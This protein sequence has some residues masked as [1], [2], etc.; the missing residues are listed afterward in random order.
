V[1]LS[2]AP[3]A[4]AQVLPGR[5]C[6]AVKNHWNATLRRIV[7]NGP[8]RVPITPLEK[9][10]H[11]L[12]CAKPRPGARP[13]APPPPRLAAARAP[14]LPRGA[15]RRACRRGPRAGAFVL[16][17]LRAHRCAQ[18]GRPLGGCVGACARG[19]AC[20]PA[21]LGAC[22]G[23]SGVWL[24]AGCGLISGPQRAG[25]KP[26]TK[27]QATTRARG[28]RPPLAMPARASALPPGAVF[29]L[30][31]PGLMVGSPALGLPPVP[32][33]PA[34]PI[35]GVVV[36]LAMPGTGAG[37]QRSY[38]LR[39]DIAAARAAAAAVASGPGPR[40]GGGA[41]RD[42]APSAAAAAEGGSDDGGAG[43]DDGETDGAATGGEVRSGACHAR[44]SA[45]GGRHDSCLAAGASEGCPA[46]AQPAVRVVLLVWRRAC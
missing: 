15:W 21:S 41:G 27:P 22:A 2:Q 36:G 11:E 26:W 46:G 43:A 8:D 28:P 4:P 25:D 18:A 40:G 5:T 17:A 45:S 12:G 31:T 14:A 1:W 16:G 20:V 32:A 35:Y 3:S 38:E 29:G 44:S 13:P 30:P 7:R 34:P 33:P 24:P 9:Y 10:L 6:N 39:I 42:G 37:A 23:S 19:R